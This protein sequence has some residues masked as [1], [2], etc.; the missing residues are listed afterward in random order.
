ML[1]ELLTRSAVRL[2]TLPGPG[3]V[4]KTRLALHI[5]TQMQHTFRDGV[6]MVPLAMI[7]EP[8]LVVPAL[9]QAL[10]LQEH[11]GLTLLEQVQGALQD[12]HTLLLLD[13][14]EHV[15]QTAPLLEDL[16]LACPSLKILVTSRDVLHLRAEQQFPV[17]PFPLP[18]LSQRA[19]VEDLAQN[20]A[21]ALFL[22]RAQAIVPTFQLT[23]ANVPA[24]ANICIALDGLPLALELAA[25]RIKTL[26][27]QALLARLSQRLALLI[28]GPRTLPERQQTLRNTLQW[29]YDLL[30]PQEQWLF[31][32][33][34]VFV[35]GC[36]LEAV[37]AV[38]ATLTDKDASLLD[39]VTVLV[40]KSLL[41]AVAQEGEEPRFVM[42]ETVREY[43]LEAL[44]ERGEI[45]ATRQAHAD[46]YL[47]LAEQGDAHL[48][49]RGQQ[50]L[51]LK[52]L[53]QEQADL[54]AAL[55]WLLERRDTQSLLR[56]SGVLWWYWVLRG[57]RSEALEWLQTALRLPGAEAPTVA[58]AK[59]LCGTAFLTVY[60]HNRGH[61][62]IALF[63]ESLALYQ[64]LGEQHGLAEMFGWF[65]QVQIY[66]KEYSAA[67]ALAEQGIAI[68]QTI[69]ERRYVA[70]RSY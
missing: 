31:R 19:D 53:T 30:E 64:R 35:G 18:E 62:G 36:T 21:V 23:A 41:V 52:R 34:S 11:R 42:L 9:A 48:K 28:G 17:A 37:E 1:C 2:L 24:V 57:S 67:R 16:L 68:S 55:S 69:G 13:N 61:E 58:R 33:L 54:R 26:P 47:T 20:P 39:L 46:Y 49:G 27:P 25:A 65:A 59:A 40:E 32:L 14:F 10:Q 8:G 3:G 50:S 4:G 22:E 38:A 44:S 51:W 56:L 45:E 60:L 15:V 66:L 63:Q 5:A 70:F 6:H 43:G 29:S 12:Q 7:R